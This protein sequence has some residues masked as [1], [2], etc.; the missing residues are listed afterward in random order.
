MAAM[1]NEVAALRTKVEELEAQLAARD[2]EIAQLKGE[3]KVEAE[4][5]VESE[6][7]V[8][9]EPKVEKLTAE[10]AMRDK[11]ITELEMRLGESETMMSPNYVSLYN[12]TG[13]KDYE[14]IE[15]ESVYDYLEENY[16]DIDLKLWKLYGGKET[17]HYFELKEEGKSE[18]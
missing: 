4:P 6:P 1:E 3:G 13:G 15:K 12:I 9:S 8:E 14:Y 18:S 7:E 2:A 11:K 16:P 5:K 10:L 17:I